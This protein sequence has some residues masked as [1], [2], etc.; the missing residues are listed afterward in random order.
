MVVL[1]QVLFEA[2]GCPKDILIEKWIHCFLMLCAAYLVLLGELIGC[3]D[4]FDLIFEIDGGIAWRG[5]IKAANMVGWI[6]SEVEIAVFARIE[7][8]EVGDDEDS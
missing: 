4:K 7:E 1:V 6:W 8:D 3:L 2:P 5:G